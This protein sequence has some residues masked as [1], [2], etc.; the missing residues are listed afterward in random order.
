MQDC[1]ETLQIQ[2]H[3]EEFLMA[4]Q[5]VSTPI[6]LPEFL[7]P[8]N[9]SPSLS[10]SSR[11]SYSSDFVGSPE[12]SHR[13]SPPEQMIRNDVQYS[14]ENLLYAIDNT[15]VKL[16]KFP[17]PLAIKTEPDEI[18]PMSFTDDQIQRYPIQLV[19]REQSQPEPDST[20]P[21]PTKRPRHDS[22]FPTPL[23]PMA[24]GDGPRLCHVCGE[25]AGKHSYYGGQV[26]PSCRAFFRRSVQSKYSDVYTC[27]KTGSCPITLKTRKNCQY[28]RFQLCERAGMKRSWVLA[29]GD[30]KKKLDP[31]ET[32][33]QDTPHTPTILEDSHDGDRLPLSDTEVSRIDNFFHQMTTIKSSP[34]PLESN[35]VEEIAQLVKYKEKVLSESTRKALKHVM[36]T[37]LR[38][39]A[40]ALDEIRVLE[41][42]ERDILLDCNLEAMLKLLLSNF[43]RTQTN[44]VNQVET[45]LGPS[46]VIKLSQ[47]VNDLT[48]DSA[49]GVE[50]GQ[51][52]PNT[53]SPW[54]DQHRHLMEK[55]CKWM[56][57]SQ[58]DGTG[59]CLLSLVLLFSVDRI[60]SAL[61][62]RQICENQQLEFLVLLKKYLQSKH[63]KH[64]GSKYFAGAIQVLMDCRDL[65]ELSAKI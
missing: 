16:Q 24:S 62:S 39:F 55:V 11:S 6:S 22:G 49:H 61:R 5:H 48:I 23:A 45:V 1:R 3:E 38:S 41:S 18:L 35:V 8:F 37:R 7:S 34:I 27:S 56:Q 17:Q 63:G 31:K 40:L 43:L 25:K 21:S 9:Q 28:C 20:F 46:D 4:H 60:P 50:Y 14:N 64:V 53:Q 33:K 12:Q 29:D 59:F 26:C 54:D 44:W 58:D 13:S 51:V 10:A 47:Q 52:F 32:V 36:T 65:Q 2:R 19:K 30:R 57:T 15:M 42:A